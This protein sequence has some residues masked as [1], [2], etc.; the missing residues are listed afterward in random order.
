MRGHGVAQHYSWRE[1]CKLQKK[2][3]L[4][5]GAVPEC[6]LP[7]IAWLDFMGLLFATLPLSI[8][9]NIQLFYKIGHLSTLVMFPVETSEIATA[10]KQLSLEMFFLDKLFPVPWRAWLLER[11]QQQGVGTS[12]SS[13]SQHE[14]CP[15]MEQLAF[16]CTSKPIRE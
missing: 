1:I 12:P 15:E 11:S 16:A 13:P 3:G 8:W 14:C 4:C 6:I 2:S 9:G 10:Q 7:R 5:D